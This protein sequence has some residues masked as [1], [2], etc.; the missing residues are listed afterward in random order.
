MSEIKISARMTAGMMLAP[1][2]CLGDGAAWLWEGVA[3]EEVADDERRREEC[4]RQAHDVF[5][6]LRFP[7]GL[8]E[9]VAP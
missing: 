6:R 5:L 7:I 8:R 2:K 1:P 9:V 3:L 4:D